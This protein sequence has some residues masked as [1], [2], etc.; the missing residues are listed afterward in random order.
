MAGT[1]SSSSSVLASAQLNSCIDC[2]HEIEEQ[3]DQCRLGC[4]HQLHLACYVRL[5]TNHGVAQCFKCNGAVTASDGSVL[6][7][8]DMG[9]DAN[10]RRM[11]REQCLMPASVLMRATFT[12]NQP[13][14]KPTEDSKT[15]KA[16]LAIK[17]NPM[18][19][20]LARRVLGPEV[21]Y[22]AQNSAEH[23]RR[24]LHE[25]CSAQELSDAGITVDHLVAA[26]I[27]WRQWHDLGYGVRDAVLLGARW[28]NLLDMGFG[29][30]LAKYGQQDY[31]AL[32][33]PPLQVSFAQLMQDVFHN[34]YALLAKRRLD[35]EVLG[36][37]GMQWDTMLRLNFVQHKDLMHFHYLPLQQIAQHME[38]TRATFLRERFTPE[39]MQHMRWSV[40]QLKQHLQVTLED[41]RAMHGNVFSVVL[42][43]GGTR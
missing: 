36:A 13:L 11:V 7:K 34:D 10:V 31:C 21:S 43:R 19:A 20:P 22:A 33:E 15:P 23:V 32:R 14:L 35:G 39:F 6:L 41:L 38:L 17:D 30:A 1:N 4:G 27:H 5:F 3:S 37:L 12:D 16:L 2:G 24:A 9:Q 25:A 40:E 26:N 8:I 28:R 29:D 42:T 18:L